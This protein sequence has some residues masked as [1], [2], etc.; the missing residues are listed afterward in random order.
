MGYMYEE[1]IRKFS[2]MSNE[3]AGEH[4]TP[5]EVIELMVDLLF[6]EDDAVL[7][8]RGV[9]WTLYDPAC[10]TGGMLSVAERHLNGLNPHAR[11]E[12][13]G[14]EINAETY[15]TCVS[16]MML[17]GHETANIVYGNTF[18]ADGLAGERFDYMLTTPPFGVDWKKYQK[19]VKD[20]HEQLGF[21]G[22]FGA[23][24][25]RVSDGSLLFL[26]HMLARMNSADWGGS[27]LAIVFNASPLITGAAGSG[28]RRQGHPE[29]SR[30]PRR[31]V[32]GEPGEIVGEDLALP[33]SS[34]CSQLRLMR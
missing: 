31:Q 22:R 29:H 9:V 28:D 30:R 18:T 20:E 14:Q 10:G 19:P 15:A 3:T 32:V 26:Q 13:F 34:P 11:L 12:V 5:R 7:R 16:D 17:K 23:G 21:S 1:L 4:F 33:A 25:P 27:R 24:V 6:I 2:E 8:D